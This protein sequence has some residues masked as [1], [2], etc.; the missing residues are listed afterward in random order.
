[1]LCHQRATRELKTVTWERRPK[2][3]AIKSAFRHK[4]P[5]NP[6][7]HPGFNKLTLSRRRE[8]SPTVPHWVLRLGEDL[9]PS[10]TS[11]NIWGSTSSTLLTLTSRWPVPTS[12]PG[13]S[14][15]L[16]TEERPFLPGV[17]F[18]PEGTQAAAPRL[19]QERIRSLGC[20]EDSGEGSNLM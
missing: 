8:Q 12:S 14:P 17:T 3:D 5:S 19:M 20:T 11:L 13:A 18:G 16:L 4:H 1:M 6:N 2:V 15:S 10:T 9:L 7:G